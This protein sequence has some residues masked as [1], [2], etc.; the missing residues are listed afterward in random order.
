[1]NK[2]NTSRHLRLTPDNYIS[3]QLATICAQA[4]GEMMIFDCLSPNNAHFV[5]EMLLF[6]APCDYALRIFNIP[7]SLLTADSHDLSCLLI[8]SYSIAMRLSSKHYRI[9][10]QN[11]VNNRSAIKACFG[12]AMI[13]RKASSSYQP[14]RFDNASAADT[15]H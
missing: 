9:E 5:R 3:Y 7:L 15:F 2:C 12:L 14:P 8:P 4:T 6:C 10:S 11:R 13:S 1:M